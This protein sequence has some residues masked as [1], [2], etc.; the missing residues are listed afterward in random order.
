MQSASLQSSGLAPSSTYP[1]PNTIQQTIILIVPYLS[2][3]YTPTVS[4]AVME[5]SLS[6]IDVGA[7]QMV[8]KF[9]SERLPVPISEYEEGRSASG[10]R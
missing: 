4:A 2:I 8:K 7:D 6:L 1:I 9:I 3:P 5:A 10:V